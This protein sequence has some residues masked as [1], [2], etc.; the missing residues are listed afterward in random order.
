M[1]TGQNARATKKTRGSVHRIP[2]AHRK[3]HLVG[4]RRERRR[5]TEL[6]ILDHLRRREEGEARVTESARSKPDSRH[7]Q[8]LARNYASKTR[9]QLP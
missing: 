8:Y 5:D 9:A 3:A 2:F 7:Q 4:A 1:L 6:G